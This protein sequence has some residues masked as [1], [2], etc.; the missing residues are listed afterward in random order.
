MEHLTQK[1]FEAYSRQQLGVAELLQVSDHLAECELCRERTKSAMP[2]DASFYALRSEVFGEDAE[3]PSPRLVSAH[4]TPDEMAGY[5]DARL[6]GVAFQVATDH[7]SGCAQCT[8]EVDDLS[9]FRNE[10]VLSLDREYRPAFVPA[11]S[12]GGWWRPTV[13]SLFRMSPVPAFGGVALAVILLAVIGWLIL[14]TQWDR[15]SKE[16]IVAVPSPSSQPIA[17]PS[18]Q[19][20]PESPTEPVSVVA[21]L[22]DGEGTLTLDQKGELSGADELTTA[23]QN[24]VK[25]ALVTRR[26]ERSAQLERLTRPASSL[27]SSDQQKGEFSVI[28]PAGNVLM[29]DRPSFRWS[30]MERATGYVVEV[31]DSQFK[32]VTSSPKVTSRSWVAPQSLA[33]GM[34]YS[35][36]V[37]AI[38]DGEEITSPRPPAP[39]AKFRILDRTKVNELVKAKRA[40]PSSHLTLGLLYADAGLLRESEQELRLLQKANPNSEIARSLLRQVQALR[41]RSE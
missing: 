39:Q 36:Q 1:Q 32:L 30:A 21:Q 4:L 38:K 35:W 27:M 6:S 33:R 41:R 15:G 28:E 37:K 20:P 16:E 13:A 29:T 17:S 7:L 14:R 24:L 18:S 31:Y 9:D 22:N 26:V 10:I 8:L 23:Y 40:H 11:S 25:K 5:V 19:P 2:G 3:I 12:T 34:V